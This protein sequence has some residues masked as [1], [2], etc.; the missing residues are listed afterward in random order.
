M[1]KNYFNLTLV[2]A[3]YEDVYFVGV[4]PYPLYVSVDTGGHTKANAITLYTRYLLAY[5]TGNKVEDRNR[6]NCTA[7][8]QNQVN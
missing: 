7:D 3:I 6:K 2:Y 8:A 1:L 4:E 5:L